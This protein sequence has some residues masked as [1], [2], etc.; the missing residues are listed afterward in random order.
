MAE[1]VGLARRFRTRINLGTHDVPN[2]QNLVGVMELTSK[3]EPTVKGTST[4]DGG[5]A[6]GNTV[7]GNAWS[8]EIKLLHYRDPDT[9][10][11]NP[12]HAKLRAAGAAQLEAN[13]VE[14][15]W[16]DV[17][18]GIE[19]YEGLAC[20]TWAPDGGDHEEINSVTVTLTGDGPRL[21]I[22]NPEENIPAAIVS[23]VEPSSGAA[24]GGTLVKI[25]GAYFGDVSG[26]ASVKFGSTNAAS[27]FV[28]DASTI[29]AVSPAGSAGATNVRVTNGTGQSATGPGNAYTYV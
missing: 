3:F 9:K 23:A 1:A 6:A 2:Y 28:E 20:V 4:Y 11:E 17:L 8:L 22:D 26:A 5:G 27:Y 10:I 13:K 19:A 21:D 24:A 12:V 18:D 7:T 16:Y 29:Y 25:T 15:Q 14:V